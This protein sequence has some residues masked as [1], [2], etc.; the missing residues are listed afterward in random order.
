MLTRMPR[1]GD[2]LEYNHNFGRQCNDPE[3]PDDWRLIGTVVCQLK[4]PFENITEFTYD[5]PDR[6][7]EYWK[8]HKENPCFIAYFSSDNTYNKSM[9]FA[10]EDHAEDHSLERLSR[11]AD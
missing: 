3:I 4:E 7:A 8:K 1:P 11:Q 10:D 2:K 6:Q 9:R 5:D